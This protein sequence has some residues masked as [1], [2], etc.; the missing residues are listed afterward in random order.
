MTKE[1]KHVVRTP[2]FQT[3]SDVRMLIEA[4]ADT[5]KK[6]EVLEYLNAIWDG[7]PRD[8]RRIT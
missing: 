6:T 8:S 2:L 3:Y 7:C 1:A 4:L 5:V